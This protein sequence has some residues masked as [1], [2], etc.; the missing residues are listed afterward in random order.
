M[1]LCINKAKY[2]PDHFH[3]FVDLI[4]YKEIHTKISFN[5]QIIIMLTYMLTNMGVLKS[6]LMI[7][8][9]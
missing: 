2:K 8:F 9:S 1:K 7:T 5:V 6:M 4:H 3:H